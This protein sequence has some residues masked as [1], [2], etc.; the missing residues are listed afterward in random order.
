MKYFFLLALGAF[1]LLSACKDDPETTPCTEVIAFSVPDT[2]ELCFNQ[3]MTNP[4]LPWP[5]KFNRVLE[6]SR[7][8]QKVECVWEGRATI[9]LSQPSA[10]KTL[11][12]GG[13]DATHRDTTSFGNIGFKLLDVQPLTTAGT[14]KPDQDYKI[15]LAIYKKS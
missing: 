14:K 6:D 9:N 12:Y 10:N 5:I 2:I 3:T 8:P 11:S 13:L 15:K 1:C 7:C 4:G